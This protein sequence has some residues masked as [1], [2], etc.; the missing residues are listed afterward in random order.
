M[1]L[2]VT[3]ISQE[4]NTFNP[5]PSTLEGFES[6]GIY[7]GREMLDRLV[8]VG[9]IGGFL[10]AVEASGRDVELVPLLK[11]RDVAG[12]RLTD[13]ALAALTTEMV[14]R[15]A[16][17]GHLDGLAMLLH[18]ACSAVSEDDVEGHLL[19]AARAVV[20]ND[21]PIVVGLDHH[22]NITRRMVELSTAIVGHRTQPHDQ[23]DTGRLT[24]ELLLRVA[25]G[26][27]A[28]VMAWRKLRLL[29]HQEQYLTSREPMKTWFDR[30]R[31]LEATDG[32][33]SASTFPVQP[34][35]DVGEGGWSVVVVADGDR[36]LAE[37]RA[38]E[39]AELA[40]SMREAFQ[41]TTSVSPVEAVAEAARRD[42][43]VILSDT[44]DSVFGGAGGDSTVLLV[45][46]LRAG[47]PTALL[48][49]VDGKAARTLAGAGVGATVEAEVGS[50]LTGWFDPATVTAT[51]R[52]VDD[53]LVL[54]RLD[55]YPEAEV[56]MGTT[57]VAEVGNVTMVVSERP[58]VAGNHPGLY[59][60]FGLDLADYGAVVLKTASNFQWYANLSTDVIRVNSTG[61]TQSDIT[62]LQWQRVPRPVYPVDDEVDHWR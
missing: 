3:Y 24:A 27:V 19:S 39:L 21:L 20:G 40:W 26:E 51:V 61:P 43:L 2:A 9:T 38:E 16:V 15:L 18:G 23:P 41:V 6:F 52:A 44:G 8:G 12:G 37:H 14:E 30:A 22:A 29:S 50:S 55:G 25:A 42:G 35:L 36:G 31:E 49:M 17:A 32:V 11:A 33:L 62:G 53:D 57:V 54:D 7:R 28:P 48:P 34:W 47:A 46:L 60:H 13:E 45:E 10:S 59:E 5:H 56:R 58:G 1:R 4:T